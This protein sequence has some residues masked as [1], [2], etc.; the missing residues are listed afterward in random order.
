MELIIK[1]TV[2]CNFNCKF[3]A[4]SELDIDH[5]PGHVPNQIK[6]VISILKPDGLIIT[7]GEPLCCDPEYYEELLTLCD[8]NIT[9]TTNLKDFWLHPDKWI[10]LFRN[11][12][13]SIG[14]SFNYGNTRCWDK[15]TVYT[16]DMFKNV[17]KLFKDN[18]GYVPSF[19][20]VI[21]EDNED[22]YLQHVML[23]KELGTY[24][25]LNNALKMGR[26]GSGYPRYKVFKMWI[27]IINRGLGKYEQNCLERSY[28]RCP[29][30]VGMM[31]ESAIRTIYVDSN[32]NVH[33]SNC[34]DKLNRNDGAEIPIDLTR[35]IQEPTV[36]SYDEA[37]SMK[38]LSCELF[39][40]CNSCTTNRDGAKEDPEYCNEMLKLKDD[41]IR[42]GWKL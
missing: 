6:D 32:Q 27:D 4:A 35:P 25:R 12:R 40:I 38:C 24:C 29:I 8:C 26:Q 22:T 11:K 21:N 39:N 36:L 18:M 5:T 19:I 20:A 9:F 17:M 31:C 10:P 30:N 3:C 1:P 37:I 23:A 2:K 34:E 13:I 15:D 16:E 14:T 33:Y 42:L 28:G 41:I 7:G